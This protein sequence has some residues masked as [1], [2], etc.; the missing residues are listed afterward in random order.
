M[1]LERYPVFLLE[2]KEDVTQAADN[3]MSYRH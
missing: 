1:E 3:D 2:R